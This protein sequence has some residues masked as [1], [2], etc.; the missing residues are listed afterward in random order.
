MRLGESPQEGTEPEQRLPQETHEAKEDREE[1]E[2]LGI[3][4]YVTDH[5]LRY[6]DRSSL[7]RQRSLYAEMKNHG[8]TSVRFD[9]DWKAM[10]PEQGTGQSREIMERYANA[11]KLMQEAGLKPP[12]IVISNPPEWATK[13]YQEG[14]KE[15]YFNAW[16][17]YLTSVAETMKASGTEVQMVQMFNEINH[18][19]LFRF[20]DTEDLPRMVGMVRETLGTVQPDLKLSTSLIVGNIND[21]IPEKLRAKDRPPL[22]EFL[23]KYE[24]IL[25]EFDSISLDYYPGVWHQ[26]LKEAG[27]SAKDTYKQLGALKEVCERISAWGKD[28]EIGEVG[29][30]TIAG[31][32]EKRQRY[33]YDSFFR[34]FRQLMVDFKKRDISLPGRV[35]LFETEDEP[36]TSF[37]GVAEKILK[38][39]GIRQLTDAVNP[40][41]HWGLM[42]EGG[43]EPKSV[44][45]GSRHKPKEEIIGL[46]LNDPAEASWLSK[47]IKYVNRPV[48]KEETAEN[49]SL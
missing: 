5:N 27:Y 29:F 36:N 38:A 35:G 4:F 22:R 7:E 34:A 31:S 23:T 16:Q 33:F 40:E 14:D 18:A 10:V 19:Q 37:G 2:P 39:G 13:L 25:K 1:R 12:T 3:D 46:H 28:Y 44:L 41:H 8:I 48:P 49:I 43:F 26:P 47:I 30:P 11:M 24:S 42:R 6:A 17:D 9:M 45:K 20:A 32:S 15:G 21:K